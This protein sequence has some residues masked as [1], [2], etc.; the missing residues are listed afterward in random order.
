VSYHAASERGRE[1][2]AV[3][4]T[5]YRLRR[6]VETRQVTIDHGWTGAQPWTQ[7][8]G[9]CGHVLDSLHGHRPWYSEMVGR[10]KRCEGCPR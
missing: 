3:T 10:R 4:N 1:A 5:R 2:A 7:L 6:V 8:I 9:E